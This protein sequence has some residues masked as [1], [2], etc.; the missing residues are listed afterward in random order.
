MK[1]TPLDDA[2]IKRRALIYAEAYINSLNQAL[3][4]YH[5][6][7]LEVLAHLGFLERQVPI[8]HK[9]LEADCEVAVFQGDRDFFLFLVRGTSGHIIRNVM[10]NPKFDEKW[11]ASVPPAS[12]RL[13]VLEQLNISHENI[14]DESSVSGTPFLMLPDENILSNGESHGRNAGSHIGSIINAE[15]PTL[16]VQANQRRRLEDFSRRYDRLKKTTETAQ[17]RG[18]KFELLWRDI[19]NHHGWS[20]KKTRK[21]GEDNDF[22]AMFGAQHVVGE[23]RWEKKPITG[24]Q[25]R[26]FTSKLTVRP[27][28]VGL[29]I[30][31][32]GFDEGAR[33]VARE[34]IK[35]GNTAILFDQNEIND[36][37]EKWRDPGE[38]FQW[39]LREAYDMLY[40]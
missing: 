26:D 37:V 20:A 3:D 36:V 19:L 31:Y 22:T 8:Y 13:Q 11:S 1:N 30:A 21:S 38:V 18:Q 25:M 2:E 39:K 9:T 23:V 6:E 40:E 32:A 4:G 34:Q 16:V 17:E 29:I 27:Q 15:L 10:G 35:A 5:K 24:S 28:S 12:K 7:N 33:S 14:L